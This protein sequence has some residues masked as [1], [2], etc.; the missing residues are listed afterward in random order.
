[1]PPNIRLPTH[2]RT[3]HC[4]F[5]SHPPHVRLPSAFDTTAILPSRGSASAISPFPSPQPDSFSAYLTYSDY[6]AISPLPDVTGPLSS[7]PGSPFSCVP[8]TLLYV[9]STTPANTPSSSCVASPMAAQGQ[10]QAS[11]HPR[12]VPLRE[13]VL[14]RCTCTL[15]HAPIQLHVVPATRVLVCPPPRLQRG[16][17]REMTDQDAQFLEA[18]VGGR[19]RWRG[20]LGCVAGEERDPLSAHAQA[21]TSA[22]ASSSP[23]PS[24]TSTP[25]ASTTHSRPA[26]SLLLSKP[27]CC[28][29]PNCNVVQASKWAQVPHDSW[30]LQLC[31]ATLRR[32]QCSQVP[33][34]ELDMVQPHVGA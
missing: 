27:F 4:P 6:S 26:S 18:V 34:C 29:K 21:S 7:Q 9:D 14:L 33:P 1:M 10:A 28:P 3:L 23:T 17:C 13:R 22:S 15:I 5:P 24:P 8:P 2:R 31:D 16:Q 19:G 30:L 12:V 20:R 25:H 32:Q 11:Y